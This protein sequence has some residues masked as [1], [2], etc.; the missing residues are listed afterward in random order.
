VLGF[1]PGYLSEEGYGDGHA[2]F[3]LLRLFLPQ[4]LAAP[5]GVL[6][7]A[8]LAVVV[9]LRTDPRR[10]WSGALPLT[11]IGLAVAGI[12]YPWYP[13]L[14]VVL[15][16]LDSRWELA[17]PRRPFLPRLLLRPAA[18]AVQRHRAGRLRH[19]ARVRAR[20]RAGQVPA[21]CRRSH[22]TGTPAGVRKRRHHRRPRPRPAASTGWRGQRSKLSR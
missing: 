20:G 9:A 10:P 17:H 11:G 8:V 15:V 13:L 7:M 5:A 22:I 12:T 19:R 6:L 16:A 21:R 14:L 2:R 3:A 1:L 4:R 18:P